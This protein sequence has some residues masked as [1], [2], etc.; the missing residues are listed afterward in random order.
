MIIVIETSN[1][2]TLCQVQWT[3]KNDE[4]L[5]LWE[6]EKSIFWGWKFQNYWLLLLLLLSLSLG[7]F[8]VR[9][10]TWNF[11]H[12]IF[13]IEMIFVLQR[14]H[15]FKLAEYFQQGVRIDRAYIHK[16]HHKPYC[17]LCLYMAKLCQKLRLC[18][19]KWLQPY[20]LLS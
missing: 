4:L 5:A 1:I 13:W 18:N 14:K 6:L 20:T 7:E 11:A 16:H 15:L 8:Y 9:W 12:W 3:N 19:H 2:V 17:K 10:K